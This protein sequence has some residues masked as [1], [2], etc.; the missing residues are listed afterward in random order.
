MEST[1]GSNDPTELAQ[2]LTILEGFTSLAVC[3]VE[4]EF[5]TSTSIENCGDYFQC[6]LWAHSGKKSYDVASLVTVVP[7][8]L[9]MDY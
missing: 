2:S 7:R 3:S 5:L 9:M 1:A 4:F 6:V 8:T